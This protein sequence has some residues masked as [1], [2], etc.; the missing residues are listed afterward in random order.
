MKEYVYRKPFQQN[1]WKTIKDD[2][3]TWGS[4]GGPSQADY[5]LNTKYGKKLEKSILS[6]EVLSTTSEKFTIKN[7]S[8]LVDKIDFS[9]FLP[10]FVFKI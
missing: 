8:F 10:Y 9:S 7:V 5:I 1:I 6:T 4:V 2:D 3:I